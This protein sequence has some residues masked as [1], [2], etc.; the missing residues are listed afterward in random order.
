V[1]KS[2]IVGI[3]A[4]HGFVGCGFAVSPR[5]ILTCAHVINAALGTSSIDEG[6][7]L[8][9]SMVEVVFP[10][11]GEEPLKARVVYWK[12]QEF[13]LVPSTKTGIEEDIAGLELLDPVQGVSQMTFGSPSSDQLFKVFGYPNKSLQGGVVEGKIQEE[14][15]CGWFQLDK[16]GSQGLWAEPGYSGS[17]IWGTQD[18]SVSGIMVARL[19]GDAAQIA[20]M[21]PVQGLENAIAHLQQLEKPLQTTPE[22][23][24]PIDQ[25]SMQSPDQ[26]KKRGL[27]KK[28]ANLQ[29]KYESLSIQIE[30][31]LNADNLCT[32]ENRRKALEEEMRKIWSAMN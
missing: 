4:S 2:N 21:I 28:Y 12:P 19:R 22:M 10:Y 23:K 24:S 14:L 5:H 1:Q 32:L 8:P 3:R 31:E 30:G 11:L 16:T 18:G 20:Y 26:I 27:E 7:K 9:E 29:S 13:S 17:A 15:P 6:K 25:S